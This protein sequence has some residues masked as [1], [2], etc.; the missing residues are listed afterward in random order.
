MSYYEE[1]PVGKLI[2]V[3]GGSIGTLAAV[4]GL[5][6][7]HKIMGDMIKSTFT[8]VNV[9]QPVTTALKYAGTQIFTFPKGRIK[10]EGTMSTI[11]ETTTSAIASTLTSTAGVIALGSS[12][13][14][15]TTLNSTMANMLASTAITPSA[16]INVAGTTLSAALAADIHVDGNSTAAPLF[17]NSAY[18]SMSTA[19]AT[20]TLSGTIVVYW[21][22]MGTY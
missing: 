13:A 2:I 6:A 19:D 9:A 10:I 21:L 17:I 12:A 22:N 3:G 5:S 15:S 20:T 14:S 1:L 11:T 7:K 16:T 8:L 4:T 18:A